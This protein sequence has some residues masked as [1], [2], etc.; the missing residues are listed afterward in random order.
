MEKKT[1][2]KI[3]QTYGVDKTDYK[4][5]GKGKSMGGGLNNLSHSLSGASAV[6]TTAPK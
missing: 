6:N 5:G 3:V 2:Q 4:A 1:G